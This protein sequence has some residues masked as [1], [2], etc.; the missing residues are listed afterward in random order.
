VLAPAPAAFAASF[1]PQP[2]ILPPVEGFLFLDRD[3]FYASFAG[4]LPAGQAVFMDDSQIR[5]GVDALG[6]TI[7]EAS[8]R[9][10]PSWYL[11]ASDD[12]MIPPPA[13]RMM[14]ERTEATV[15]EIP[16]SH[17]V[18]LSQPQAVAALI[19]QAALAAVRHTLGS[20]V[21]APLAP[22]PHLPI[23]Q[24]CI[25]QN[26]GIEPRPRS[27]GGHDDLG[28]QIVGQNPASH[29]LALLAAACVSSRSAWSMALRRFQGRGGCPW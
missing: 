4:D 18:Y 5:W 12:R 2:P 3:K 20:A 16:G 29:R 21:P 7:S 17:S 10:K 13:Q 27:S 24:P 26:V 9:M 11:V 14:A 1:G 15:T 6:G 19:K 22:G 8:W 23:S 28:G 25:H